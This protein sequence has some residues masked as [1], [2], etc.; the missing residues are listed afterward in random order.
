MRLSACRTA[1]GCVR[2]PVACRD[3]HACSHAHHN[4][5]IVLVISY[6]YIYIYII[7]QEGLIKCLCATETFSMGLNMPAKT[8]VFTGPPPAHPP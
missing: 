6:I 7:S 1:C 4:D 5:G 2:P 8:V 3:A